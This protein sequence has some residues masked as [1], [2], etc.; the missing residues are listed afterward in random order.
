MRGFLERESYRVSGGESD[1]FQEENKRDVN[2]T[3]REKM[4]NK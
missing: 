3:R 4:K 2:K 1:L